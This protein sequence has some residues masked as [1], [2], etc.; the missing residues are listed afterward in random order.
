MTPDPITRLNDWLRTYLLNL[1]LTVMAVLILLRLTGLHL[2]RHDTECAPPSPTPDALLTPDGNAHVV[3]RARKSVCW[4]S[5]TEDGDA[6]LIRRFHIPPTAAITL[7]WRE[8][9]GVIRMIA[10]DP[11]EPTVQHWLNPYTGRDVP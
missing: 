1:R 7:A 8:D 9:M 4:W 6:T 5:V 3:T 10:D 2:P 11:V